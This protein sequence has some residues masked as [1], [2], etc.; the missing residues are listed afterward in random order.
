MA[1]FLNIKPGTLRKRIKLGW[2][3]ENWGYKLKK[4]E[5][6]YKG[7]T[8][9]SVSKLAEYLGINR[10]TLVDRINLGLSEDEWGEVKLKAEIST[11]YTWEE[12]PKNLKYAA[13][14]LAIGLNISAMEA[15]QLI[16]E[17]IDYKNLTQ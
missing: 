2:P 5:V 15:Y 16:L 4:Y 9:A 3:Q 10:R 14:K 6:S 1:E 17:K 13:E 8:Y 12:A 11:G 7:K